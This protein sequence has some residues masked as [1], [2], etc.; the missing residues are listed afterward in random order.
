MERV[1]GLTVALLTAQKLTVAGLS[2]GPLYLH[3]SER[4]VSAEPRHSNQ[5]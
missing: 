3:V 5:P 2:A 4:Y 1:C